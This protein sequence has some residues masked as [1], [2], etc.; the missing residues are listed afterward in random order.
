MLATPRPLLCQ[1]HRHHSGTAISRTDISVYPIPVQLVL[2]NDFLHRGSRH[3]DVPYSHHTLATDLDSV[4][5]SAKW[6]FVGARNDKGRIAVG[7][8]GTRNAVLQRTDQV[9]P[10]CLRKGTGTSIYK[11]IVDVQETNDWPMTNHKTFSK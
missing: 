8:V 7:D 1:R 11:S 9:T 10:W 6:I 3:Y 2:L 4:P 5:A